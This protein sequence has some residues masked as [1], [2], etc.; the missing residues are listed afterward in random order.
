MRHSH[1]A[2]GRR[3]SRQVTDH[4]VF[5][6]A[7]ATTCTKLFALVILFTLLTLF[8][9]FTLFT[10]LTLYFL[11]TLCTP[12]HS[13]RIH[14]THRHLSCDFLRPLRHAFHLSSIGP[15]QKSDVQRYRH[16]FATPRR[17]TLSSKTSSRLLSPSS[18]T[19]GAARAPTSTLRLTTSAERLRRRRLR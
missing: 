16:P 17:A 5:V 12:F 15:T 13:L 1:R 2:A 18:R 14:H 11:C 7:D 4:C 3:V 9:P 8:F 6:W 19:A 10:F